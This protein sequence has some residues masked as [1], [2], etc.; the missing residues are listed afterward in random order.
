MANIVVGTDGSAGAAEALRF[1][2]QEAAYRRAADP[3]DT[4]SVTALMAW[5]YLDQHHAD[6]SREFDPSYDESKALEAAQA[7]VDGAGIGDT[8]VP[9]TAAVANQLPPTAL[10]AA[11]EDADLLVVGSRGLGGFKGLLLGSVSDRCLSRSACPVAVIPAGSHDA[12]TGGGRIVVGI[13]GSEGARAALRWALD[14]GRTRGVEV[15]ALHSW[16]LPFTGGEA[17]VPAGIKTDVLEDGAQ[18]LLDES[19]DAVVK[20]SDAR[21]EASLVFAGAAEALL[22]AAAD[23]DLLVLGGRPPEGLDRVLVGS[24]ARQVIHHAPCPVVVVPGT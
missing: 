12:G 10:V 22:T 23:A 11:S 6:G 14:E 1:A 2:V 8:D 17:F 19:V 18:Q 13:D 3:G 16:T 5:G 9:V 15:V 20:D 7:A 21:P 4:T 24:T